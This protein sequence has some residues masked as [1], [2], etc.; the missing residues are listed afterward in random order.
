[1]A[2]A[3]APYDTWSVAVDVDAVIFTFTIP[4]QH[5]IPTVR[6]VA[7][8]PGYFSMSATGL[9][10][11]E[12]RVA[13]RA[14]AADGVRQFITRLAQ[15]EAGVTPATEHPELLTHRRTCY[16]G[17]DLISVQEAD[18]ILA[19]VKSFIQWEIDLGTVPGDCRTLDQLEAT[20]PLTSLIDRAVAWV[21]AKGVVS[22]NHLA[23]IRF[24]VEDWLQRREAADGTS[25]PVDDLPATDTPQ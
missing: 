25:D 2:D 20:V 5:L 16:A 21:E 24:A 23:L 12:V 3:A 18:A 19:H 11:I 15:Q 22:E 13:A 9:S 8:L 1:M 6:E 4:D 10:P 17:H 7:T 14:A